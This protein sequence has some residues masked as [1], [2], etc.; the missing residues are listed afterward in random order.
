MTITQYSSR[1]IRHDSSVTIY[2]SRLFSY[3]FRSIISPAE[4]DA[5][6]PSAPHRTESANLG[7]AVDGAMPLAESLFEEARA[8]TADTLGVSREPYGTGAARG[9][10]T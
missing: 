6:M 2:P 10:T 4:H 5:V 9:L 3:D 1:T 7:R 8:R